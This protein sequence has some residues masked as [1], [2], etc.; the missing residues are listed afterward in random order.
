MPILFVDIGSG[1]VQYMAAM[2]GRTHA[3]GIFYS[4]RPTVISKLKKLRVN[5]A[6]G[7]GHRSSVVL[8]DV[9]AVLD[10]SSEA[11]LMS[12]EVAE[13]LAREALADLGSILSRSDIEA[14]FLWN[15]SGISATAASILAA[16]QGM[17]TVYGENGYLPGT[18]QIDPKGVNQLASI[19][20]KVAEGYALDSPSAEDVAAYDVTKSRHLGGD[21]KYKPP[22][23]RVRSSVCSKLQEKV[24]KVSYGGRVFSWSGRLNRS[25]P[26]SLPSD[27]EDFI[28]LPMQVVKDSQLICHSPL[29]HNDM[30]RMIRAVRA[31]MQDVG[32]I[33][34]VVKVHPAEREVDYS[35]LAQELP[36]VVFLAG[37]SVKELLPRASAVVTVNSTVGFEGLVFGK[38]V[39]MLGQNFYRVGGVVYP[40]LA[41]DEIA[42]SISK[43]VHGP[44]SFQ[45]V[46]NFLVNCHANYFVRGSWKDF[47][48][49]SLDN[50]A[51][52]V[53][54]IVGLQSG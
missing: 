16:R 10:S 6:M 50:V 47:S 32:G 11:S 19:T 36:D 22:E 40:V 43:A 5:L 54:E 41:E 45:A 53:D 18:M 12:R 35:R 29:F 17:P 34:L 42:S 9:N 4:R 8:D 37:M 26:S 15:G 25:I 28:L 38:G 14:V 20:G 23:I 44:P 3:G 2:A 1:I 49:E 51:R 7:E 27:V 21:N 24:R 39:V 48:D 46:S 13:R 52:R 30:P 33:R 31:A